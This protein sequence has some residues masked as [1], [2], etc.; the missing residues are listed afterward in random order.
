MGSVD[1]S[2]DNIL[3]SFKSRLLRIYIFQ[4]MNPNSSQI[5]N[6]D[7][8]N[9]KVYGLAEIDLS[10]LLINPDDLAK[11]PNNPKLLTGWYHIVDTD[12]GYKILGQM[13]VSL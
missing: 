3:Q 12:D 2:L 6:K 10:V 13:K 8:Q 1:L 7:S 9:V 4:K 11:Y 5:F